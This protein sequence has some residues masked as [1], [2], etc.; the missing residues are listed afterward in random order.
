[1]VLKL[2]KS[3]PD[4]FVVRRLFLQFVGYVLPNA[5]ACWHIRVMKP[6]LLIPAFLFWMSFLTSCVRSNAGNATDPVKVDPRHYTV[7][8]ENNHLRVLRARYGPHEKSPVH[9]HP[10]NVVITLTGGHIKEIDIDGKSTEGMPKGHE[11]G[12]GPAMAH[13]I[14][15]LGDVPYEVFVVELK[16]KQ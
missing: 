11:I 8:F 3:Q 6:R 14:E 1:M 12:S 2:A 10:E 7:E 9:S 4:I 15:N 16:D 13:S 5:S